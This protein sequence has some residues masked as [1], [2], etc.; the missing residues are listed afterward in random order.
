VQRAAPKR[1][2]RYPTRG[3]PRRAPAAGCLGTRNVGQSPRRFVTSAPGGCRAAGDRWRAE[4][5]RVPAH[6]ADARFGWQLHRRHLA[7]GKRASPLLSLPAPLCGSSRDGGLG[8]GKEGRLPSRQWKADRVEPD[9]PGIWR[10]ARVPVGCA[11]GGRHP[12]FQVKEDL[13]FLQGGTP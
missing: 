2:F 12:I 3:H 8:A 10:V 13:L 6:W 4:G 5:G 9:P 11:H 7:Q 1:P